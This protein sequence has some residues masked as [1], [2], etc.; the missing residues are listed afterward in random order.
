MNALLSKFIVLFILVACIT[1]I[2]A[3]CS[4]DVTPPTAICQNV[5]VYLD[6]NGLAT[7]DAI[8]LDGGS[9]DNCG[10]ETWNINGQPTMALSCDSLG[11]NITAT[12]TVI[13]T[14]GNS[15]TC[16]ANVTVLDTILPTA[17]C[18]SVVDVI[19]DP[20]G[21]YTLLASQ[22]DSLSSDNCNSNF[23]SLSNSFFDCNDIGNNIVVMTVTDPSGNAAICQ[24]TVVVRDTSD[25]VLSCPSTLVGVTLDA[26]GLAIVNP[27]QLGIP[28]VDDCGVSS[29]SINGQSTDT[30]YCSDV[31]SFIP[32]Y[33]SAIDGSGN[34][35]FCSVVLGVS[36]NIP[37][38]AQCAPAGSVS[39]NIGVNGTVAFP[40]LQAS[41]G[42]SDNCSITN[43]L[44]NGQQGLTLTCSDVGIYAYT[45]EVSDAS[46]N[47]ATCQSQIMVNWG[48]ACGFVVQVDSLAATVC[49]STVCNGYVALS[50]QGAVGAVTYLWNDGNTAAVRSNLCA[51][52]YTI[53]ASDAASNSDVLTVTVGNT[54]GCVWPGDTDDDALA[55]NYDLL[56]IALAYGT[57]GIA[58]P[59]ATL[60][61]QGQ[62]A[63]DWIISPTVSG[64]PNYKHIDC[65][66]DALI[67]SFDLQAINL[68]Y[69]QSYLRSSSIAP[70]NQ[71]PLFVGCDTVTEGE[72]L[73]MD[74]N[75]G[76]VV[77]PAVNAYALAYSINYDP[78][79]IQ[80]ATVSY[81]NSWFGNAQDLISVDKDFP[82]QGRLEAAVGRIDHQPVT[83]Y[84][85]IG[86]VCFT[87]RDDILRVD[88][89]FVTPDTTSTTITIN[90]VRFI[91]E[92]GKEIPLTPYDGCLTIVEVTNTNV[93]TID[94]LEAQIAVY[95][96]PTTGK[97]TIDGQGISLETISLYAMTGQLIQEWQPAGAPFYQVDLQKMPTAVYTISIKTTKGII[98]KKIILQE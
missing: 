65:N 73:C 9:T 32:V 24:S 11:I 40:T 20:T 96:N 42:S 44:I 13:D 23:Y 28:V 36:D 17:S 78:Q 82:T 74:L 66:G 19:L 8:A 48:T 60:N 77:L 35:D 22:M 25:P 2:Q 12:L 83:G 45:L 54:Q 59:N 14:A 6:S 63:P 1:N 88:P 38:T 87:I 72:R 93:N 92:Q 18:R 70:S 27:A 30:F 4:N 39:V 89:N 84:G 64:L 57:P 98:N 43:T 90:G 76:N 49:D 33:I 15:A 67:D 10:I 46:G 91:D 62:G 7:L 51:G 21:N 16:T 34:S 53:T 75:L 86:T 68:N 71:T 61:W 94:D 3:Q 47:T 41:S 5:T 95:P 85:A 80:A 26:N 97:L 79:V 69:N 55:N 29:W 58:R 81:Q 37:P 50:T 52:V 31:G 56:P